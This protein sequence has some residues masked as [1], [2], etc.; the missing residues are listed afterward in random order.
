VAPFVVIFCIDPSR[1][2]LAGC[3]GWQ[4][5]KRHRTG[6]SRPMALI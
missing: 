3:T 5:K 2:L 4:E 1:L 6:F